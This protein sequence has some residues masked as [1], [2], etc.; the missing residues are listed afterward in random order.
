MS[1]PLKGCVVTDVSRGS[2]TIV[3][4]RMPSG[5][6]I[7]A[8]ASNPAKARTLAAEEA[9]RVLAEKPASEVKPA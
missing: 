7:V 9:R 5:A 2:D 8:A 6:R 1:D 4:V 3:Y